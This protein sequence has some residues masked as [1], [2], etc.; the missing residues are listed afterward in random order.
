MYTWLGF[1]LT[2]GAEEAFSRLD[3]SLSIVRFLSG[4]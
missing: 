3:N 2:E 4:A 1:G